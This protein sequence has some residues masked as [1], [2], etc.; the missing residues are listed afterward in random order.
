MWGN[1]PDIFG[2]SLQ[3]FYQGTIYGQTY[4]F[5]VIDIHKISSMNQDIQVVTKNIFKEIETMALFKHKNI[6]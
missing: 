1:E 3:D 4:A 2:I 5:K 6:L